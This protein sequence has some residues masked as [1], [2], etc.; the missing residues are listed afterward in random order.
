LIQFILMLGV[1]GLLFLIGS[2]FNPLAGIILAVAGAFIVVAVISATQTIFV[3]AVYHNINNDP[4][5]HF[6]QQMIDGLFQEKSRD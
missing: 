1:G 3:S 5:T 4:V 2:I 6:N